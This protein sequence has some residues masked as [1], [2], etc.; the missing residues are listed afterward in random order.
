[1]SVSTEVQRTLVKSPPELWAELGSVEGLARHLSEVGQ[2]RVVKVEPETRVEWEADQVSGSVELRQSGWG[3]KVTLS[4]TREL[5]A[6]DAEAP[7]EPVSAEPEPVAEVTA[8]P[9]PVAEAEDSAEAAPETEAAQIA[10]AVP[11]LETE[12]AIVAPEPAME[13]ELAVVTEAPEPATA[14]TLKPKQGLFARLFKRRRVAGAQVE[15]APDPIAQTQPKAEP[16]VELHAMA[17]P[18]L[19]YPGPPPKPVEPAVEDL[20]AELAELEAQ[21]QQESTELLTD[22][23]DRLG[24]AHHRPFSRA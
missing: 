5:P 23:L 2:I 9:E 16:L 3:T 14:T 8:E 12:P 18:E 7:V 1:M 10:V 20:S 4:L 19:V 24:A 22:V 13:A 15:P 17:L 6:T 21:M 11:E